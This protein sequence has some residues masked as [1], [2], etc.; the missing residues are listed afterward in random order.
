MPA[1]SVAQ[2]RVQPGK[3]QE[4]VARCQEA[5]QLYAKHGISSRLFVYQLAGPVSGTYMFVSE[6]TDLVAL[7][8]AFENLA[9]DSAWSDLLNRTFGPDGVGTGVGWGQATEVPL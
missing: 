8:T 5:K 4:F 9:A 7:A 6:A 1:I 2:V 3:A